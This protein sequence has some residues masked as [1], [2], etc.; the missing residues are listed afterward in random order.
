MKFWKDCDDKA[1][2]KQVSPRLPSTGTVAGLGRRVC[3]RV[4][5]VLSLAVAGIAFDA[6]T[7]FGT[8]HHRLTGSE[9][10]TLAFVAFAVEVVY[11]T[12]FVSTLGWTPG[13]R[14]VGVRVVGLDNR[15]LGP[16]VA[17]VRAV[18]L[19]GVLLIPVVGEVV[20]LI[21]FLAATG[22]EQRR[23][24][25][26]RFSATRVVLIGPASSTP[27]T[28]ARVTEALANDPHLA[29]PADL[30]TRPTSRD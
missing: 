29:P 4:V 16:M 14:A 9:R 11:D 22:N 12:V 21:G 27:K 13:K 26:D 5:D 20:V 25:W 7:G 23:T 10:W 15:K 18:S 30:F 6:I 8:Y 17:L 19:F 2:V 3:G 24:L 1:D 28:L